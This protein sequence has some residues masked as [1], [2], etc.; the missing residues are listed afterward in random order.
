MTCSFIKLTELIKVVKKY[1]SWREILIDFKYHIA[2]CL[3]IGP[4]ASQFCRIFPQI[5]YENLRPFSDFSPNCLIV[6]TIYNKKDTWIPRKNATCSVSTCKDHFVYIWKRTEK[7]T[8]FINS[9][10]RK[11]IIRIFFSS[12]FFGKSYLLG[13]QLLYFYIYLQL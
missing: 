6:V 2:F 13:Y 5:A 10:L 1:R 7:L 8:C 12:F 11:D 9:K 4:L 3:I